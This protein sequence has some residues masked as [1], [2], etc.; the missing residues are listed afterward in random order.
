MF[1]VFL[2][3]R[4]CFGSSCKFKFFGWLAIH[5][6]VWTADRLEARRWLNQG[7]C[8]LCRLHVETSLHL[9]R[10]C[11]FTK[12]L[13]K[14]IATGTQNSNLHPSAWPPSETLEK[15]WTAMSNAPGTSR[16]GLRSLIILVCWEIWKERNA[17]VFERIEST[18]FCGTSE[19]QR[20][21]K[22]VDLGWS[23]AP[24]Y[25]HPTTTSL[26]FDRTP[27]GGVPSV[28]LLAV[29]CLVCHVADIQSQF[30]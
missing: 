26:V 12:R 11:G 16:K 17:R 4:Q 19:N 18:N 2:S 5:N 13:W 14:E 29:E 15:W 23:E 7:T 1:R 9:F 3:C 6:W 22:A 21:G 24:L 25:I 28:F 30:G 10:D 20:R 8:T 27:F